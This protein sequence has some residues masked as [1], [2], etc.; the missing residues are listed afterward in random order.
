MEVT[1]ENKESIT[2]CTSETPLPEKAKR[3]PPMVTL[4]GSSKNPDKRALMKGGGLV[5]R[6]II[7]GDSPKLSR[8]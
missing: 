1:T 2:Y 6:F 5:C 4:T 7:G 3:I 8:S